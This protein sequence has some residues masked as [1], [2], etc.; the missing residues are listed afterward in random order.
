[1]VHL[2][3]APLRRGRGRPLKICPPPSR[4]VIMLNFVAVGQT[5]SAH[6]RV[7]PLSAKNWEC[8]CAKPRH[9]ISKITTHLQC[10]SVTYLF[11]LYNLSGTS[12]NTPLFTSMPTVKRL[13]IG[14]INFVPT[15]PILHSFP[16]LWGGGIQ[17]LNDFS[18]A[19]NQ[20]RIIFIKL[21]T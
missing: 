9:P 17:K 5:E 11:S 10:P 19:Q 14:K 7:H 13:F 16:S 21:V 12:T 3:L 6:E 4:R 1:M 15:A 20:L 8:A 2:G 18:L